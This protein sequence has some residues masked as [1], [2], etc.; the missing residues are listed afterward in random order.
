MVE[1]GS[2]LEEDL[3]AFEVRGDL[4]EIPREVFERASDILAF[5]GLGRGKRRLASLKLGAWS[6]A[7]NVFA[8]VS[9]DT[10][11]ATCSWAITWESYCP[12]QGPAVPI[13]RP[14]SRSEKEVL[15]YLPE[16]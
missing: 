4:P 12:L 14:W 3:S 16:T 7:S 1:S 2:G 6:V 11:P 10:T 15:I 5:E 13:L 8:T 9:M